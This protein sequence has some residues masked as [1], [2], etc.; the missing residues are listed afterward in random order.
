LDGDDKGPDDGYTTDK[1][2]KAAKKKANASKSCGSYT[3]VVTR[4]DTLER[5]EYMKNV[6]AEK[7]T[8]KA[9]NKT[10][11]LSTQSTYKIVHW[12]KHKSKCLRIMCKQIV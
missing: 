1:S 7:V 6:H 2:T 8:C 9:C 3:S 4:K 5:D 10:V 11:K 12:D